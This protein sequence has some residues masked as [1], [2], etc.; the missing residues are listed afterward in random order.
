MKQLNLKKPKVKAGQGSA[1]FMV[2]ILMSVAMVC[3][4]N[5]WRS[6]TYAQD[7]ALKRQEVVLQQYLLESALVYAAYFVEENFDELQRQ[8][9]EGVA[10]IIL[11]CDEWHRDK[12]KVYGVRMKLT[13]HSEQVDVAAVLQQ[14]GGASKQGKCIVTHVKNEKDKKNRFVVE[15]WIIG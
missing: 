8:R 12:V 6:T 14:K 4:T 3:M 1:L 5:L 11:V 7:L 2:L 9:K 15:K 13:V 10:E